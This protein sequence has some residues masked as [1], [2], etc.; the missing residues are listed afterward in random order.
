MHFQDL[1]ISLAF[2]LLL[3]GFTEINPDPE[4]CWVDRWDQSQV[5]SLKPVGTGR[6][7]EDVGADMRSWITNLYILSILGLC[8][9]VIAMAALYLRSFFLMKINDIWFWPQSIYGVVVI[10]WGMI[11]RF[12]T[13]G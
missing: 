5:W 1:V 2:V 12:N 3:T 4:S 13:T 7:T 11:I 6:K 8:K 10:T 9:W